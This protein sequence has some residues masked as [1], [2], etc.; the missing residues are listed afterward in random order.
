MRRIYFW[1]LLFVSWMGKSWIPKFFY[2]SLTNNTS[3]EAPMITA[4]L[5]AMHQPGHAVV[6]DRMC[7]TLFGAMCLRKI[8]QGK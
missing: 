4:E 3:V 5:D 6:P 8:G 2:G 1:E 7:G